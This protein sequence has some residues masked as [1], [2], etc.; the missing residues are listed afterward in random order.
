MRARADRCR[1]GGAALQPSG[2]GL[3]SSSSAGSPSRYRAPVGKTRQRRIRAGRRGRLVLGHPRPRERAGL[4][5]RRGHARVFPRKRHGLM[6]PRKRLTRMFPRKRH[7]RM[8]P[9]NR[10]ALMFPPKR[11]PPSAFP[12]NRL[13]LPAPPHAAVRLRKQPPLSPTRPRPRR[14]LPP[15]RTVAAAPLPL[16]GTT[17]RRP[18][19]TSRRPTTTGRRLMSP[20]RTI[21]TKTVLRRSTRASETIRATKA[22]RGAAA[23]GTAAG[24]P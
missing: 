18:I 4:F 15:S 14:A 7:A 24:R 9:P 13:A 2:S 3:P 10:P 1:R 5:P 22:R 19:T 17:R 8:D 11:P 23:A 6:F 16:Q 21:L 12:R 20:H